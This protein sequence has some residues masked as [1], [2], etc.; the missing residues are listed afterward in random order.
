[1]QLFLQATSSLNLSPCDERLGGNTSMMTKIQSQEL[2]FCMIPKRK[3][4]K[5]TSM[6]RERAPLNKAKANPFTM[7][8]F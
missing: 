7:I 8:D 1:M 5:Q 3:I 6:N 4:H 2:T